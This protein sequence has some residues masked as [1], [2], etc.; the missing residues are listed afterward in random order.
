MFT[1]D[2][3]ISETL[4]SSCSE[5]KPSLSRDVI[6]SILFNILVD[7][8]PGEE[9]TN[10]SVDDNFFNCGGD[11]MMAIELIAAAR[12]KGV[13]V[14]VKQISDYPTISLLSEN[15]YKELLSANNDLNVIVSDSQKL[16]LLPNQSAYAF[17]KS[18]TIA[19]YLLKPKFNLHKDTLKVAIQ[20]LI[21]RHEALRLRFYETKEGWQQSVNQYQKNI[22]VLEHVKLN[23][24]DPESLKTVLSDCYQ[25]LITSIDIEK[26]TLRLRTALFEWDNEQA[27]FL[28][29]DHYSFDE[30][31]MKLFWNELSVLYAQKSLPWIKTPYHQIIS[32]LDTLTGTWCYEEDQNFWLKQ[33][34]KI[35]HLPKTQEAVPEKN[36]GIKAKIVAFSNED[37]VENFLLHI[38]RT[39][40]MQIN[41]MLLACWLQSISEWCKVT[42]LVVIMGNHN[43]KLL[44]DMIH[45]MGCFVTAYPLYIKLPVELGISE[46]IQSLREQLKEVPYGGTRY[47]LSMMNHAAWKEKVFGLPQPSLGFNYLGE[48][49]LKQDMWDDWEH[50]IK[51]ELVSVSQGKLLSGRHQST[52]GVPYLILHCQINSNT[53]KIVLTCDY[54]SNYYAEASIDGLLTLY[55]H[56]I[57]FF[58]AQLST[59]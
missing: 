26:D 48:D 23:I 6:E 34:E 2:M 49:E 52:N 43:R 56:K 58:T 54:D 5:S 41:E 27:F 47:M 20:E 38:P 53:K 16:P 24:I 33:H 14:G 7:L 9:S 18:M 21:N 29:V 15:I 4:H 51:S 22:P 1:Q 30:L 59:R 12:K 28:A 40:G 39:T 37:W 45:T 35:V 42:G 36:E 31:S 46:A 32:A 19:V 25:D 13:K 3:E 50:E 55:Q 10:L 44:D 11:S 8:L 17:T 57:K